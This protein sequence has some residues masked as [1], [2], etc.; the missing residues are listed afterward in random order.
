MI[1]F[2]QFVVQYSGK[3]CRVVD[4]A[5]CWKI[6]KVFSLK[7]IKFLIFIRPFA[8]L[9]SSKKSKWLNLPMFYPT[10]VLSHQC[11]LLY[12]ICTWF[13]MYCSCSKTNHLSIVSYKNC[14]VLCLKFKYLIERCGLLIVYIVLRGG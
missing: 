14:C 9:F 6:T 11:F 5:N 13:C 8:K 4:L 12:S 10:N 1:I 7:F 3:C 2:H